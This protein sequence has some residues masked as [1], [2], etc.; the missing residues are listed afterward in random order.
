MLLPNA[1][2]RCQDRTAAVLAIMDFADCVV[3]SD[4]YAA[5]YFYR[6]RTGSAEGQ[7]ALNNLMPVLGPCL[8]QGQTTIEL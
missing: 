6:V 1:F 2:I 4:P 3:E 5:D 8:P 7:N